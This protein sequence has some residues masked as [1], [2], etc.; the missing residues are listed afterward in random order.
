MCWLSILL[1]HQLFEHKMIARSIY[2]I[3]L[4]LLTYSMKAQDVV[5]KWKFKPSFSLGLLNGGRA[6]SSTFYFK[7]GIGGYAHFNLLN[8]ASS[9]RPSVSVGV[10]RLNEEVLMPIGL[11]YS[12]RFK[13]K[14]NSG[15]IAISGGYALSFHETY[16]VFEGY[17]YYG[18][19]FFNPGWG[20]EWW[21]KSG[22]RLFIS[23]RYRHQFMKA[24]YHEEGVDKYTDR[25]SYMMLQLTTGIIF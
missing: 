14:G 4:F 13:D 12:I 11:E 9:F 19:A 1:T 17:E 6:T 18:G 15:F 10:E 21:L 25:F 5:D 3:L 22:S 23:T 20:Y 2:I 16:E 8:E 7:S 24:E